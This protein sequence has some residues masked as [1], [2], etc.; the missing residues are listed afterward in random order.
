MKKISLFC[1]GKINLS[2]NIL[3]RRADGYHYIDSIMQAIPFGD[4]LA[5]SARVDSKVN[6]TF[7]GEGAKSIGS[8]NSVQKT[9][10]LLKSK[11]GEFGADI[12]VQKRLPIAGGLGGSSANAAGTLVALNRLFGF[13]SEDAEDLYNSEIIKTASSIGSDTAFLTG[14]ILGCAA[15][16]VSGVGEIITPL[17]VNLTLPAIIAKLP[18][19]AVSS[20][21]SYKKFD[22]LY[23]SFFYSP[24]DNSKL[25]SAISDG[26]SPYSFMH[27]ALQNSSEALCA[28][29]LKTKSSI[30]AA[31]ANHILMSGSGACYIGFFDIAQNAVAAAK[32]LKAQGFWCISLS[33]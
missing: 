8:S 27:N 17:P 30:A 19:T 11:F 1:P 24:A 26:L 14:A 16:R 31:K 4:T 15:A 32:K 28:D 6:I 2:L 10:A 22:T 23:P 29:L 25:A 21:D 20:A 5:A 7:A 18:N 3:G 9:V 12:H 33:T 13:F